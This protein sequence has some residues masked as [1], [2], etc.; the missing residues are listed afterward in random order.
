M[1]KIHEEIP[2]RHWDDAKWSRRHATELWEKYPEMWIAIVNKKVVAF[3][4]NLSKV[5]D[6]AQKKTRAKYPVIEFVDGGSCIY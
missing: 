1:G 5:E 4:K 3:G 6:L 2:K